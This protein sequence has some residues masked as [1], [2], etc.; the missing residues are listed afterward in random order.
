MLTGKPKSYSVSDKVILCQV[1]YA[2]KGRTTIETA[3]KF[4]YTSRAG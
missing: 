1:S 4:G 3:V 2:E